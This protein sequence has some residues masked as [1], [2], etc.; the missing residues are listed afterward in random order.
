[1]QPEENVLQTT[2]LVYIRLIPIL[3]VGLGAT[4]SSAENPAMFQEALTTHLP[5]SEPGK[6]SALRNVDINAWLAL[7]THLYLPAPQLLSNSARQGALRQNSSVRGPVPLL[8]ESRDSHGLFP[9]A[10][11]PTQCLS[12]TARSLVTKP[13]ESAAYNSL[14]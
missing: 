6:Y 2:S 4:F 8:N 14:Y 5:A 10:F 12:S 3:V 13:P 11:L 1:M 7:E 9:T